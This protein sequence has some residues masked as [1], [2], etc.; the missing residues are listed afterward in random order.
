MKNQNINFYSELS[1]NIQFEYSVVP[2]LLTLSKKDALLLNI[3]PKIIDPLSNEKVT[4][5]FINNDFNVFIQQAIDLEKEKDKFSMN[6]KLKINNTI[7]DVKITVQVIYDGE[8]ALGV[9]GRYRNII[10]ELFM[11]LEEFYKQVGGNFE[12]V[13]R[14]LLNEEFIRKFVL[15]FKDDETFDNLI[16]AFNKADYKEAFRFIHTLKGTSVNLGFDDLY[17]ASC[18]LTECLRKKENLNDEELEEAGKLLQIVKDN[19]QKII[20][21]IVQL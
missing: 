8:E 3:E 7:K 17:Q 10:G 20:E 4:K 14:R 6:T 15:K 11:E 21:L 2:P 1:N 5:L 19:Y 13:K 12:D 9:L 16:D 18:N